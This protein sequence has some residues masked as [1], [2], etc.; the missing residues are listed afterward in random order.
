MKDP[1][2]FSSEALETINNESASDS[3]SNE[4]DDMTLTALTKADAPGGRVE[5]F[6]DDRFKCATLKFDTDNTKASGKVT[7]DFGTGCTDAKG[8]IR[9]GII[10]LSWKDGRWFNPGSTVITTFKDYSINKV[11]FS[12]DDVRTVRNISTAESPLTWT[13]EARHKL[14]WPNGSTA[15]REARHTRQWVRATSPENDKYIVS[16]TAGATSAASGVNRHGKNF[17]AQITTPLQYFRSCAISN[18]VFKPVI[19]VVVVTY[20]TNKT[21]TVDF[22]AGECDNTFTVSSEGK[23]TTVRAKNDSSSD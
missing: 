9:K 7:I 16:Q 8:N 23:T 6:T 4:T 14:T 2:P 21:I 18:K 22:G 1:A 15:T 3:Q 13:V 20:N 17:S 10:T 12:N 19:G 11:S 5:V